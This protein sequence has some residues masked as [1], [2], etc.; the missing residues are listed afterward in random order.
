M[1]AP[2]EAM[3]TREIITKEAAQGMT[4]G[5]ASE[6]VGIV[7]KIHK[8]PHMRRPKKDKQPMVIVRVTPRNPL[9]MKLTMEEKGKA[10]NLEPMR[11]KKTLKK[12]W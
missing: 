3:D 11:R 12:S 9:R 6:S 7:T 2:K 5:E 10:V 1:L 4:V 8:S